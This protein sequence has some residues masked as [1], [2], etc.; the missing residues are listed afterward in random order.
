MLPDDTGDLV[1][2]IIEFDPSLPIAAHA[3]EIADLVA[4]HQ[5]VVVA[6]ETGSGKT[7]QLP[8]ICLRLG[9]RRI[10][11]TQPRRIA[12]RSVA[13]RIAEE[14]GVPL[15]ELVGYQV[16]FTR[17]ATRR[18]RVKV[19][20]DGVLLAEIGHDRELRRYDTIIIDEAHERSLNIDF[21]LGYLKQLLPR[22]PE[23]RVIITSA[24]IDTARFAEHFGGAPVIEVSG[25]TYP[26]EVRY[27][28]LPDEDADQADAIGRA[29]TGL[30][31]ETAG[32]VLVFLSGEREIRDADDTLSALGLPDTETLPL[33]ARLSSAEQHR[34]FAPHPGRRIVLAT[35]VAETSL[36]VPGIRSVVDAGTARISRYSAR[37]KVQRLPI[38]PISQA[39]A[40]Q[41]AGRCGRLGPGICVRLY[42]KE[43]F[44]AR[45]AYTEPE[46]LRTNLA[47]V[48]LQMAQAGLGDIE[49]FPFVEAPDRAQ[50]GDGM[51]L[52]DELGALK[53]TRRERRTTPALTRI[54][55]QLARLPL[56]P[57]LGRMHVQDDRMGC[58]LE[59]QSIVSGLA[60]PDV[61]ERPAERREQAD[62]L[63]RRFW[64]E[65]GVDAPR[66][67]ANLDAGGQP[68][69]H[70]VHTGTRP[71]SP[72]KLE[73]SPGGDIMAVRRL[74]CYLRDQRKTLSGNAFRRLC[75]DEYLNFLRVRE[76]EDLHAQ[77][78]QQC[79]ELGLNRNQEPAPVPAVLT[80]VLSGLL[81]HVGLADLRDAAPAPGAKRRRP[82]PREYLG[83]R[84]IRFA[85][86][87]GSALA[88]SP[89]P[90]VMAFEL[91]DTSRLWARMVSEIQPE[92]VE[93]VGGHLLTRTLSDPHWSASSGTVAAQ[94][95]V[96]LL[97]VPIIAQRLVNYAR[98]DPAEAHRIFIRSAL[99]E[100]QWHTRHAFW[101]HNAKLR[102]EA[103]ELEERSRRH[104]IVV[105]DDVIEAF[106][107]ERVPTDIVSTAM[108]DAWWHRQ[109]DKH[110]L[111]LSLDVLV[112]PDATLLKHDAYPDHWAVAG[113]DVRVS[114]VF[115]PG[116]GSDGVS[117]TLPL[118][119]LN[120]I[121]PEPFSWQVPGMREDLATELIR[122]LPKRVRTSFVPAPNYA[123]EALAW[124]AERGDHSKPFCAELGRA[125]LAMTGVRAEGWQ[126]EAVPDHLR[127][128]FVITDA[129]H[130]VAR[131]KDFDQLRQRLADQVSQVLTRASERHGSTGQTSWTFGSIEPTLQVQRG[132]LTALGYPAL[133][134]EGAGVGL[135]VADS[136]Q[137]Q[138]S[139]HAAGLRRLLV[140]T[141]PDP[142]RWV[143]SHLSNPD[144]LVLGWS[145]Y[146]S[147][148]DLLADARMKTMER[149][150]RR[151]APGLAIWTQSAFDSLAVQV[152][153]EKAYAMRAVV[154]TA[155]EIL[156]LNHALEAD[157]SRQLGP[158][159]SSVATQRDNLIFDRFISATPDAWFDQLPRYLRGMQA[160]LVAAALHP[161]RDAAREVA[162]DQIEAD[163]SALC[164]AQPPGPLPEPV[165]EIGYLIEELRVSVFAQQLRTIV[166]VSEKRL[167][168]AID[169][170]R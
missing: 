121:P 39:S 64:T 21:L 123:R 128:T 55:K 136:P 98:I 154:A 57:P 7:T 20:T 106:Y 104:D 15:G 135:V 8:K 115:D 52:L 125:L 153:Q 137:R 160:R 25:R 11:Q 72:Q 91:V 155:A 17:Q 113:H 167:R 111:D 112:E 24:T 79:R 44:E 170:L 37:T 145:P 23:L 41:R 61:R 60:I 32:D 102:A 109:P 110:V 138:A 18:T 133:H 87:P 88:A 16:R 168:A 43:D 158:A 66:P 76:W 164:A 53:G 116:S 134:D 140:L 142:T 71:E 130:E 144:K 99:V 92:W 33:Y 46:I 127:I 62:R 77:L 163:Y 54:G 10:A 89:P 2:P 93:E 157:L 56:Y 169:K 149:L 150:T 5:V 1:E 80:A 146:P 29:V 38:E 68:L 74:W 139:L 42:S 124:L 30:M 22:R 101:Q 85:I 14:L 83:A 100:G 152:R 19:M 105:G 151:I 84:G 48:I 59:V 107:A 13:E 70:T 69:R 97:G 119:L 148:A 108:F 161:E 31:A 65:G 63:H 35:N 118:P 12:A 81:S 9:R 141:L 3:D 47:A 67:S 73:P 95:R 50:I 96:H 131:G 86:N 6:G 28:P 165:E 166:P 117:V 78:K 132:R 143:V 156:R 90:L 103:E 114:Y 51:R 4:A 45:P 36:T 147:V 34:V 126:P 40:N 159:R 122:H 94:E 75:R 129:G 27:E 82:G 120:Q 49:D 58:L 26:V 162:L